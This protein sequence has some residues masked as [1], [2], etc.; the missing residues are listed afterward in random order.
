LTSSIIDLF[1][2]WV[3]MHWHFDNKI[4]VLQKQKE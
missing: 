1:L 4:I 3:A 2:L